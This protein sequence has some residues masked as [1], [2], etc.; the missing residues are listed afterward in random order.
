M[1][2]DPGLFQPEPLP[3]WQATADLCLCRRHS[4]AGLAQSLVVF[5]GPG[6]H[7]VL[8]DPSELFWWVWGLF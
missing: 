4:N 7:K 2:H 6:V 8:F 1:P 5:L 3:L